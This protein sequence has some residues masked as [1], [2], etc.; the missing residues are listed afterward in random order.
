MLFKMCSHSGLSSA[1]WL[2][3][4]LGREEGRGRDK[5]RRGEGRRDKGD[6]GRI[7]RDRGGTER[8]ELRIRGREGKFRGGTYPTLYNEL[9][10]LGYRPFRNFRPG[11][12]QNFV[13]DIGEPIYAM[14]I[15]LTFYELV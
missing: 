2:Y 12:R 4:G 3:R 9:R 14:K 8:S 15:L 6:R 7:G 10:V 5:E 11:S 13:G 1:F